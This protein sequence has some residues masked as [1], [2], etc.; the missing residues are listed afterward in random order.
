M[1]ERK[2]PS[3]KH[4]TSIGSFFTSPE[5][6][7]SRRDAFSTS[8]KRKAGSPEAQPLSSRTK[9]SSPPTTSKLPK[10][11]EKPKTFE[12]A[13]DLPDE[14]PSEFRLKAW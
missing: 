1:S 6:S 4:Q 2:A 13:I 12:E 11:K 8:Q 14:L 3:T 10:K 7:Q 9:A 5:G